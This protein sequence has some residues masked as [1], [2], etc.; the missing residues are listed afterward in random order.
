MMSYKICFYREIL[1]IIPDLF[2]LPLLI[3]STVTG[4]KIC[5]LL[6]KK[7]KKE[8][9]SQNYPQQLI[10]PGTYSNLWKAV[11]LIVPLMLSYTKW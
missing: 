5:F 7:K 8:K 6:K 11:H 3:W 4:Q 9:V 2:L 10:L 1:L